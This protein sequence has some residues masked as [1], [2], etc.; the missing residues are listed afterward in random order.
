MNDDNFAPNEALPNQEPKDM[1]DYM[2][3][4]LRKI[5]DHKYIIVKTIGE[6]RYAK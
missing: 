6:G 1:D 4:P 5:L 3:A 2:K